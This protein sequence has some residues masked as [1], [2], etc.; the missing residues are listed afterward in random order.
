MTEQTTVPALRQKRPSDFRADRPLGWLREEID[1]LLEDFSLNRPARSAFSFPTLA[2]MVGMGGIGTAGP[3]VELV[4]RDSGYRLTVE[5]PG[6]AEKDLDIALAEGVLAISGEK[7]EESESKAD[8]YLISERG[9]GAFRRQVSLPA[10][11]DPDS[12]RAKVHDGLLEID[13]KKDKKAASRRRKIA[14]G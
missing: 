14:I 4:E 7:R 10:D 5:I 2:G 13:M 1:R 6:I 9:Y 3:A 12:L 11:V 8:G